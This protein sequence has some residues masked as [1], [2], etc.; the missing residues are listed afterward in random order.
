MFIENENRMQHWERGLI[1]YASF[2]VK[3]VKVYTEWPVCMLLMPESTLMN[4][5]FTEVRRKKGFTNYLFLKNRCRCHSCV[6]VNL[7]SIC[8][9]TPL[10]IIHR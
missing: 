7:T 3:D 6:A 8:A 2:K 9:V 10:L 4:A 1:Y 5:F